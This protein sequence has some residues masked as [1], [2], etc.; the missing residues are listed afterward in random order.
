MQQCL[1]HQYFE[2]DHD[3]AQCR[4][5]WFNEFIVHELLWIVLLAL[6]AIVLYAML[7][8]RLNK[9][10]VCRQKHALPE[11]SSLEESSDDTTLADSL[12]EREREREQK[13]NA[14]LIR[15]I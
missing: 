14:A 9:M 6:F 1:C 11:N 13:V 8:R 3:S 12:R 5:D 7:V 2:Y 10:W 15:A 4:Y